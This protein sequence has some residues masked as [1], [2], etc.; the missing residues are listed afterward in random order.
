VDRAEETADGA[1]E[2]GEEA[3]PEVPISELIAEPAVPDELERRLAEDEAVERRSRHEHRE[4]P[5][6]RRED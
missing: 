4:T 2:T 5:H 6:F 1:E 3:A